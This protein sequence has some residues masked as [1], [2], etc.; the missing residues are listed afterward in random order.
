M[1]NK[2]EK[3]EYAGSKCIFKTFV[4]SF[5][6]EPEIAVFP[7]NILKNSVGMLIRA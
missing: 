1:K 4:F 7:G 3:H 2:R 6:D 5:T